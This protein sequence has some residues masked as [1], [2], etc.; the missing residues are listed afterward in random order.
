MPHRSRE[1]RFWGGLCLIIAALVASGA[2]VAIA[3]GVFQISGQM[4]PPAPMPPPMPPV[5]PLGFGGANDN[6]LGAE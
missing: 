3:I 4:T 5:A 6:A 2:L 1:E